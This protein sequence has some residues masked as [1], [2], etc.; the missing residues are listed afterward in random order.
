M[1]RTELIDSEH[2]SCLGGACGCYRRGVADARRTVEAELAAER[3]VLALLAS[4]LAD[5]ADDL[6]LMVHPDDARFFDEVDV[7]PVEID[8]ALI[9]GRVRLA[10]AV[11]A[12]PQ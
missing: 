4:S 10:G 11:T 3:A 9:R 5:A 7:L 1:E 8:P 12:L 6:R 2:S